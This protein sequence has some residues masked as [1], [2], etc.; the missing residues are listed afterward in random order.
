MPK[1]KSKNSRSWGTYEVR[2]FNKYYET[3]GTQKVVEVLREMGYHRN[4]NA[5]TRFARKRGIYQSIPQGYISLVDIHPQWHGRTSESSA[6]AR[7]RAKRDGVLK[8]IGTGYQAAY[9]VPIEWGE[10]YLKEVSAK[11]EIDRRCSTWHTMAEAAAIF[12]VTDG[13]LSII[14]KR[15]EVYPTVAPIILS[16]RVEKGA[17]TLYWEPHSTK[18]AALAYKAWRRNSKK[19]RCV[20]SEPNRTS[21]PP[22]ERRAA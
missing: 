13:Y 16:A 22:A 17:N 9:I 10:E 19:A 4:R 1:G 15:P 3:E 11:R 18:V 8:R 7:K 6:A 5:V 2:I 20:S 21:A 14:R 12:G